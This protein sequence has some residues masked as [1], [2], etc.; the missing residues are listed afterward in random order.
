M[1]RKVAFFVNSLYGG[2]AEKVLQTLLRHLDKSKFEVTLY[3]LHKETVD[4]SYPQNISYRYI[5]GHGK[6]TDYLK[7][8]VYK[9]FS[10]SWFYRLFVKGKYDTEVAFIEGYSTRIVS[11]STNKNSKKIAWVHIDL[12]NNHWTDIAFCSRKEEREC[13]GRYDCVV[14]VSETVRKAAL[15]LF[16]QINDSLCLYNPIDSVEI[17]KKSECHV[18]NYD[19]KFVFED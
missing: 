1:K 17:K 9:C 18:Y 7:T 2:G 11:G 13:Y 6:I 8:F 5:Y 12:C 19:C 15:V 3:S 14:A 16:P 10:P 4:D